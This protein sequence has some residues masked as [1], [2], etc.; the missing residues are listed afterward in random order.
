M[1]LRFPSTQ[2]RW[3]S[4]R[5]KVKVMDHLDELLTQNE[6]K[7]KNHPGII[8]PRL[9]HQPKWLTDAARIILEDDGISKQAVVHAGQQLERHLHGRH[10]PQERDAQK[11]DSL[12]KLHEKEN[13]LDLPMR[14]RLHPKIYKWKPIDY[15]KKAGLAY[16]SSRGIPDYMVLSRIFQEIQHRDPNFQPKS[17]FDFASG[18]GTV[19]WAAANVWSST[20][21]EYVC[22]DTSADMIDLAERILNHRTPKIETV[23]YRQ[24]L[25]AAPIP[26]Y[27]IVVSAYGLLEL[28]SLES[29]LE[30]ICKLW[31]KTE[32]YLVI[33]EQG[34]NS[35]FEIVNEAR[36]F[37]LN[38]FKEGDTVPS[39]A[40]V[41]APC[42]HEYKCPRFWKDDTPC[43]FQIH[44]TTLPISGVAKAKEELYSYVV[45]KKGEHP[46]NSARWPRIVRPVLK[47]PSHA[48]CRMCVAAGELKEEIFTTYK[49]GKNTYRC[50]RISTWGD[51]LPFDFVEVEESS[52]EG[53]ES[54]VNESTISESTTNTDEKEKDSNTV[55]EED[56]I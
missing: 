10:P 8:K 46:E 11:V 33:V 50:A 45:I 12:Y 5:T 55:D 17:L 32:Q 3:F 56:K 47:R 54:S 35:G 21:K 23:F 42:P 19:V 40:H 41:F 25:P 2:I 28:P 36:D 29:R 30:T 9:I 18:I 7:H 14:T 1:R 24:H 51:R 22:I 31:E 16:L 15:D 43:N 27:D 44:Y 26:G 52:A 34:T 13:N 6:L 37:V 39:K 38:V 48:I 20:L 4:T 49:N 53:K